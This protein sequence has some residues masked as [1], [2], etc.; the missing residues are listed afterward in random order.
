[1]CASAA[2]MGIDVLPPDINQSQVRFTTENGAIRF[3]L[4][5]VKNVGTA[6]IQN[7]IDERQ[8]NGTFQ[9]YG[10]FLRRLNAHDVSRK[11]IESLIRA[12]ALDSFAIPRSRLIA[13][14]EPFTSQLTA[15][16]RQSMEGQLSFFELAQPGEKVEAEPV[17][18]DIPEFD[19][20]ELLAME[21]EML[22]LYVS[23]HPLDDFDAAIRELTTLDSTAFSGLSEAMPA[24]TLSPQTPVNDGDLVIMAGILN[25]RKNKATRNDK[26]M[27][28]LTLEDLYGQ[29][30]VIVFPNV[31]EQNAARLHEGAVLLIAGR[32]SMREEEEPKLIA[33]LIEPLYPESR[34][35]PQAMLS[36]CRGGR[37][38]ND[39]NGSG[40][41]PAVPEAGAGSRPAR[42]EEKAAGTRPALW[43]RLN[44]Q[45]DQ[46]EFRRLL[47][48]LRY[49]QGA[50]P[51][52]VYFSPLDQVRHL[53]AAYWLDCS[54][55][56]LRILADRYGIDNMAFR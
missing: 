37:Q 27:C 22:G 5:A 18:P 54:D 25:S 53:E 45:P 39:R 4:A 34:Q 49:F 30:E 29:Y 33:E 14:L 47:A 1:M 15:A 42:A 12:S 8:Q 40:R 50:T 56:V 31:L 35:L 19:H 52:H 3:A 38:K 48:T 32:L 23:G 24:E 46:Q 41:P 11:M 13:V 51:V 10:D 2:N 44:S 26:M 21:K 36:F 28:F 17:Y 43:L 20:A 9:S 16:R 7:L 55:D 6:A